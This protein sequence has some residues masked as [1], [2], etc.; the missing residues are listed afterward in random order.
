MDVTSRAWMLEPVEFH[1]DF[2]ALLAAPDGLVEIRDRALALWNSG[3]A[4]VRSYVE[5]LPVDPDGWRCECEDA[6]LVEWYRMLMAAYLLPMPSLPRPDLVR[7]GFPTLGWH[8]AEARRV[9]RGRELVTLAERHLDDEVLERLLLRFGWNEKGW[10]DHEDLLDTLDRLCRLERD[11]FRER[12][13]LVPVVDSVFEVFEL[14]A[15]KPDH[16]MLV[17][18]DN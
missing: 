18:S 6:H 10:L 17:L 2:E 15:T 16:V 3:D 1:R 14:A 13:E 4:V 12:R 7:H 9:A 5:L 11:D 8:A